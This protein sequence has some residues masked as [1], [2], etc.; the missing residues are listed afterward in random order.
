M[1]AKPNAI[2]PKPWGKAMRRQGFLGLAGAARADEV[3]E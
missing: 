1:I 2:G 3:I